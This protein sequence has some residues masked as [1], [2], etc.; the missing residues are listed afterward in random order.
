MD[1]P[2]SETEARPGNHRELTAPNVLPDPE[3]LRAVPNQP[4]ASGTAGKDSNT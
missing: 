2:K 3:Y 1:E 4:F